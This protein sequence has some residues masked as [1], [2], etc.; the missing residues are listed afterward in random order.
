MWRAE[1]EQE[2]PLWG[3]EDL[4]ESGS[5]FVDKFYWEPLPF[6]AGGRGCASLMHLAPLL[7]FVFSQV[8][9]RSHSGWCQEDRPMTTSQTHIH[10][11]RCKY[12]VAI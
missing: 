10:Q 11:T 2:P 9:R 1:M 3:M 5:E 7:V 6:R 8:G 12:N 4:G